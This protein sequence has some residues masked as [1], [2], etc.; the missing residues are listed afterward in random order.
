MPCDPQSALSLPLNRCKAAH[1]SLC[2]SE[3]V[4]ASEEFV[5]PYLISG[6]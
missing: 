1:V 2:F 6:K 4:C 3:K 5:T